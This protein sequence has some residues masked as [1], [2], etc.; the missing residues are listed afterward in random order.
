MSKTTFYE[1]YSVGNKIYFVVGQQF[2]RRNQIYSETYFHGKYFVGNIY[3]VT[4]H[5]PE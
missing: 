4:L 5:G 1:K 2:F 3:W